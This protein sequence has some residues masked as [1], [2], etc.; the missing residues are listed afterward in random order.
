MNNIMQRLVRT[1]SVLAALATA[2]C[3]SLEERPQAVAL[4]YADAAA[5]SIE[6][7]QQVEFDAAAKAESF[8]WL[9]SLRFRSGDPVEYRVGTTQVYAQFVPLTQQGLI[10]IVN[11]PVGVEGKVTTMTILVQ[12]RG[13]KLYADIR[14]EDGSTVFRDTVIFADLSV[15]DDIGR[16][17]VAKM[18]DI[19]AAAANNTGAA[20]VSRLVPCNDCGGKGDGVVN[21][22][23]SESVSIADQ[24]MQNAIRTG[25]KSVGGWT[26]E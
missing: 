13:G 18:G 24:V 21:I 2:A 1:L 25:I 16:L 17:I 10:K 9:E 7:R 19:L 22:L 11:D 15:S 4:S 14:R 5:L 3:A 12:A 23:S 20:L 6:A 26:T 8:A